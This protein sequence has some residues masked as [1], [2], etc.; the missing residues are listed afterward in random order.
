MAHAAVE[1]DYVLK[2]QPETEDSYLWLITA[3]QMTSRKPGPCSVSRNIR[4][5]FAMEG[6]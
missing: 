2:I 4:W 5:P 6:P 3:V 1:A